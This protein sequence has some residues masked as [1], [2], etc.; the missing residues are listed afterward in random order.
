MEENNIDNY[1]EDSINEYYKEQEEILPSVPLVKDGPKTFHEINQEVR[2][3]KEIKKHGMS[4]GLT[5][6]KKEQEKYNL[7]YGDVID[8]NDAKIIK[9]N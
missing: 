9:K 5:F 2:I 4:I 3:L 1:S 8:L 7:Q 6:D